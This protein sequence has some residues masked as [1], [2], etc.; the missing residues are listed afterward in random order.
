MT[1]PGTCLYLKKR[2]DITD[3]MIPQQLLKCFFMANIIIYFIITY[4]IIYNYSLFR[5]IS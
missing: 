5:R 1:Y 2:M 3:L 4:I